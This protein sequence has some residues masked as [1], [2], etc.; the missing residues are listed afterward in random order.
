MQAHLHKEDILLLATPA[1]IKC[2]PSEN[3]TRT[4]NNTV[5]SPVLITKYI[6]TKQIDYFDKQTKEIKDTQLKYVVTI[7]P[8]K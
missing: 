5:H 8:H 2:N 1:T 6:L 3:G 7:I 4:N